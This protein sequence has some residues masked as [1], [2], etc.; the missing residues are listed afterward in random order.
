M[1]TKERRYYFTVATG[2]KK[3]KRISVPESKL[4][5]QQKEMIYMEFLKFHDTLPMDLQGR[6]LVA[7]LGNFKEQATKKVVEEPVDK[8]VPNQIGKA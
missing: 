4:T 7:V 8:I 5:D 3:S 1:K 2:P 6:F